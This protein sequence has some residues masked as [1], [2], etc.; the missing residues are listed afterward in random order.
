MEV[1]A[2]VPKFVDIVCS[3]CVGFPQVESVSVACKFGY[4]VEKYDVG[5]AG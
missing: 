3:Q 4:R 5:A 2:V 1:V